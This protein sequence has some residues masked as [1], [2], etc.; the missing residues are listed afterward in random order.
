M[1]NLQ[2]LAASR[3][4]EIDRMRASLARMGQDPTPRRQGVHRRQA[5]QHRRNAV[6]LQAA[7]LAAVNAGPVV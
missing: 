3:R 2:F 5:E 7:I 1:Q 4:A 6:S